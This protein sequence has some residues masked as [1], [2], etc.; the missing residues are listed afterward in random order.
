MS[1]KFDYVTEQFV[2]DLRMRCFS[3][4]AFPY[5]GKIDEIYGNYGDEYV[6]IKLQLRTIS[7]LDNGDRIDISNATDEEISNAIRLLT[8]AYV[9][10]SY[11]VF[12]DIGCDL[13]SFRSLLLNNN[14]DNIDKIEVSNTMLRV[15]V[16]KI[17]Y[18]YTDLNGY[19]TEFGNNPHTVCPNGDVLD[20][21]D[22]IFFMR[23]I[24]KHVPLSFDLG[25][26]G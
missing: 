15:L 4:V 7:Q 1:G 24:F 12:D 22:P 19:D 25:F 16:S 21:H 5:Y 20:R 13:E 14:E 6:Q 17:K 2:N 9:Y 8:K 3:L 26:G 10:I 18:S 11:K 23:C